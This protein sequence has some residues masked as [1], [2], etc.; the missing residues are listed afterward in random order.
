MKAI[1]IRISDS[2]RE[3]MK[4]FKDI[5]WSKEIR[6][7]IDKRLRQE[8]VKNACETQDKLRNKASGK[9]SGVAEIRKWRERRR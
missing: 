7:S 2:M 9:W 4:A 6:E 3:E 8:K 5:N 1:S